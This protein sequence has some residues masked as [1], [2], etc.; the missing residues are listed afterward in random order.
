M[1]HRHMLY[2]ANTMCPGGSKTVKKQGFTLIELLVVIAII[3]ILAAILFPVFARAREKARQSACLS[4]CKQLGLAV[5]QYVQD[6]DGSFPDH[7]SLGVHVYTEGYLGGVHIN[8]Y[9]IRIWTDPT[10]TTVGGMAKV[11]GPYVKNQQ[12]FVCPSDPKVD[13]WISGRERGSYYMRHAIDAYAFSVRMPANESVVK[14]PSQLMLSVEEAWHWG[15]AEPWCWTTNNIGSNKDINA[16]FFD[17][18]AKVSKTYWDAGNQH[19]PYY[20]TNWFY[21]NHGWYFLNDPYD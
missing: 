17:G 2:R 5:M 18:H 21:N 11:L 1:N 16:V 6:Y 3:A 8:D 10:Q 9:A 15:G 20:D 19:I 13:R 7:A 4:N 14:R 12:M